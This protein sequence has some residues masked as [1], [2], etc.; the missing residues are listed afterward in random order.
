ME[1]DSAYGEL[2]ALSRDGYIFDGW[3]TAVRGGAKVEAATIVKITSAQTLYA[4]WRALQFAVT[5][6]AT[7]GTVGGETRKSFDVVCG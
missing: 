6:D 3:Y 2:P 4:R 1:Y 5:L 7:P